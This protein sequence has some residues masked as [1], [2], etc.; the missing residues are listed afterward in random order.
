MGAVFGK[1]NN[2]DLTVLFNTHCYNIRSSVYEYYN[3]VFRF[4]KKKKKKL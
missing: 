1:L 3:I 4:H 2:S